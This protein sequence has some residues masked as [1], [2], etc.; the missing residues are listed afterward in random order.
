[1]TIRPLDLMVEPVCPGTSEAEYDW[2]AQARPLGD[3]VTSITF[4]ATQTFD[5]KGNPRDSDN[6]K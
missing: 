5:P 2:K 3:E 4:N 1:M 6:D